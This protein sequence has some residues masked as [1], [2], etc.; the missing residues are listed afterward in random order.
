MT[1]VNNLMRYFT[2]H[3]PEYTLEFVAFAEEETGM[4]GSLA[5]VRKLEQ[6]VDAE[7]V[8]A[9]INVDTLGLKP[10][11]I[12]KQSSPGLACLARNT[13]Q[14]LDVEFSQ[15][16]WNKIVGD[17]EPFARVGIPVLNLH[18][19][20]ARNIHRIHS[21]KDTRANVDVDLMEEAYDL[22]LNVILN[23]SAA[24]VQKP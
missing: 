4:S 3:Q 1:I 13:A 20:D 19:V 16:R 2:R 11:V 24:H 7:P 9:M 6:N 8:M 5:Y 21:R 23:L 14:A 12:D 15:S 22:V 18:S 10:V 17:W